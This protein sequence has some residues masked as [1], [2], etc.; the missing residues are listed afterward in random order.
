MEQLFEANVYKAK[1]TE[2]DIETEKRHFCQIL[3]SYVLKEEQ[4]KH[5]D[6]I[7]DKVTSQLDYTLFP[8][9]QQ[10]ISMNLDSTTL[11]QYIKVRVVMNEKEPNQD[12]E[13]SGER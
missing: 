1:T 2:K 5:N 9:K 11:S 13:D 6:A 10:V 3:N 8:S 4:D 7:K 12:K